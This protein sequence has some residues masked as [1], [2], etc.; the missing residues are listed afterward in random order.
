VT[1]RSLVPAGDTQTISVAHDDAGVRLDAYLARRLPRHSRARWQALI[2]EGMVVVDGAPARAAL[3]V[4]PGMRIDIVEPMVRATNNVAEAIPLSVVFED[5]WV[6]VIDKAA[7]MVVHPAAGVDGG[8]VVNALLHH[9]PDLEIGGEERPGIV[10]RLDKDTSG[11][12]VCA[13]TDAAL[14]ALQ[15]SFQERSVEKRYRAWCLGRPKERAFELVTGH[16]RHPRDRK[17]FT[18]R[19]PPPAHGIEGPVRRAA[20]HYTVILSAH[21]VSEVEV[22]LETGRT[23]QIRAQLSDIGHPILAD[24]MYGGDRA[25]RRVDDAQVRSAVTRLTRQALHAEKLAFPHPQSGET[26]R[27]VAPLPPDLAALYEVLRRRTGDEAE[28][29]G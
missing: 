9:V 29:G 3:K 4:A 14:R 8:T 21:G 7:G 6:I 15:R 28:G 20:A 25:E 10:H 11:L 19:L 5:E 26:M 16:A 23:H 18:T 27:F 12:L 24:V 13:K 17:R 1:E 22:R 2:D